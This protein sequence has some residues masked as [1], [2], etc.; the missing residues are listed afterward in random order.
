MNRSKQDRRQG[1]LQAKRFAGEMQE[2]REF[3]EK[4]IADAE[5][6]LANIHEMATMPSRLM[7]EHNITPQEFAEYLKEIEGSAIERQ[8]QASMTALRKENER[9]AR[10]A[11]ERKQTDSGLRRR[12][13]R[14][15]NL[16]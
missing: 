15:R 1:R 12:V 3:A 6:L 8:F 11:A 14:I 7:A 9:I 10:L 4:V 13:S 2:T 16:I 5:K